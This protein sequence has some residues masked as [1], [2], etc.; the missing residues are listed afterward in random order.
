MHKVSLNLKYTDILHRSDYSLGGDMQSDLVI[1]ENELIDPS[2][3][4]EDQRNLVEDLTRAY[5]V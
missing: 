2:N 5:D 3:Y 1:K 4:P